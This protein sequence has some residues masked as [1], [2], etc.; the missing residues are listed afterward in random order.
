MPALVRAEMAAIPDLQP[1]TPLP[2]QGQPEQEQL[3]P[4][5]AP[6]QAAGAQVHEQQQHGAQR[7]ETG[8]AR[9]GSAAG[10]SGPAGRTPLLELQPSCPRLP[11]GVA[12]V[13]EP[14]R[15]ASGGKSASGGGLRAR[16]AP[17]QQQQHAAQPGDGEGVGGTVLRW[18]VT[19]QR[20]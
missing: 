11:A 12:A 19:R 6:D 7:V 4:L 16:D 17:E 1:F 3:L 14:A 20:S 15:T 10:A 18:A 13:G 5:P 8:S 2:R 9:L